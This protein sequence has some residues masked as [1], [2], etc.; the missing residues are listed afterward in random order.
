M[1]DTSRGLTNSDKTHVDKT[2]CPR[3]KE[4]ERAG[5]Q[6]LTPFV[7]RKLWVGEQRKEVEGE[8]EENVEVEEE[9]DEEDVDMPLTSTSKFHQ[10]GL[11]VRGVLWLTVFAPRWG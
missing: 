5:L 7:I 3:G 6:R 9:V 2:S 1:G 8:A 10:V 11:M 4:D